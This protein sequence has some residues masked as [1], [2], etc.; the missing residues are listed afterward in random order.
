MHGAQAQGGLLVNL[1][2]HG[3]FRPGEGRLSG[4]L[5]EDGW[6]G[7]HDLPA[8]GV[9]NALLVFSSCESGLSSHSPGRDMEGWMSAGFA[10]GAR[11]MVLTLW[12]VDDER[13]QNFSRAFYGRWLRHDDAAVAAAAAARSARARGAHAYHWAAAFCAG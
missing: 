7:L 12:K 10:L 11:E 9:K 6:V 5:L 13:A 8:R 3:V 2:A 4:L 1:A